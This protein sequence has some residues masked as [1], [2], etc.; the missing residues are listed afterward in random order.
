MTFFDLVKNFFT[1]KDFLPAANRLP[2]TL[3]TPLHFAATPDWLGV[4][5]VY[6]IYLLI[7]ALP[8]LPFWLKGRKQYPKFRMKE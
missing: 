5:F 2:G 3:L 6:G 7:H 4:I 8:Y 1:H